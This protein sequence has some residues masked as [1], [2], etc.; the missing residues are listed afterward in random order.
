MNILQAACILLDRIYSVRSAYFSLKM[1]FQSH[2]RFP[3]EQ[4]QR[5]F[6]VSVLQQHALWMIGQ[7]IDVKLS[8]E[9]RVQLY[10]LISAILV[11]RT[12]ASG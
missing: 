6:W 12:T 4:Q 5:L 9:N 2:L 7:W 10:S 8:K 1:F 11:A 3:L